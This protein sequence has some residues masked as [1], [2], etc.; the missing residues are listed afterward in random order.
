MASNFY[1]T[2]LQTSCSYMKNQ[3]EEGERNKNQTKKK[4]LSCQLYC[5]VNTG[6]ALVFKARQSEKSQFQSKLCSS[7]EKQQLID[8]RK[9]IQLLTLTTCSNNT[10]T[11][12][13]YN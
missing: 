4:R 10:V 13:G 5:W 8:L 9:L 7:I 12:V 2:S 3:M 11:H 6:Q 1:Q